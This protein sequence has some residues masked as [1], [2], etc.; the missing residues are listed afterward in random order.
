[1]IP[2][3]GVDVERALDQKKADSQ[4]NVNELHVDGM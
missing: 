3:L 2:L 4:L 1:M